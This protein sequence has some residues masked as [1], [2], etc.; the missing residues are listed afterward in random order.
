MLIK[1]VRVD[2]SMNPLNIEVIEIKKFEIKEG[3]VHIDDSKFP[4]GFMDAIDSVCSISIIQ[5]GREL[6]IFHHSTII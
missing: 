5:F 1:I 4:I 2:K 3:I 6:N